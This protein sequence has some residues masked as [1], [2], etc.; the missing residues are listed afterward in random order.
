MKVRVYHAGL[1]DNVREKAQD[2]FMAGKLDAIVATN[3]FGMGVDKSDIRLVVHADMPRSPEAYYQEAGRG[4]RDG[5]PT[6]WSSSSTADFRLM[7]YHRRVLSVAEVL[8]SLWKLLRT[9]QLGAD[10][11]D[12]ARASHPHGPRRAR[13]P[14]QRCAHGRRDPHPRAPRDAPP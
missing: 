7:S 14:G 13:P 4:G 3:A 11:V 1:E 2:T 5:T 10:R 12:R 8:R 6:R 9:P